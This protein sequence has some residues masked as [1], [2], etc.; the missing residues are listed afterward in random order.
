MLK[1]GRILFEPIYAGYDYIME[2]TIRLKEHEALYIRN[3]FT[4]SERTKNSLMAFLLNNREA[5]INAST[6]G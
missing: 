3:L 5:F 1:G 4:G 2:G 6:F